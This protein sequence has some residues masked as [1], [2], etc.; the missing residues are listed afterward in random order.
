MYLLVESDDKGFIDK[1][2]GI[3]NE[4]YISNSKNKNCKIG[5]AGEM[6]DK[7]GRYFLYF[8]TTDKK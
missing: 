7:T 1:L 5:S 8:V 2:E 4:K 3:Y 6:T